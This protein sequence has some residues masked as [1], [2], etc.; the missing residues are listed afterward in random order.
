MYFYVVI[1]FNDLKAEYDNKLVIDGWKV[2]IKKAIDMLK[3][4][5]YENSEGSEQQSFLDLLEKQCN[6]RLK[7]KSFF[8]HR[9]F[10]IAFCFFGWMFYEMLM[11]SLF[12]LK[13]I[14]A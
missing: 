12:Y 5:I 1:V 9:P 8:K 6:S 10:L 2:H 4:E 3:T 14:I 11:L 7:F 13:S